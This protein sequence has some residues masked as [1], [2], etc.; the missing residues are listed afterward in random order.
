MELTSVWEADDAGLITRIIPFY[1]RHDAAIVLDATWGKGNFWRY[2][3]QF[4]VVGMDNDKL[5]HAEVL[6]DNQVM[7]F[8]NDTFDAIMYDPP[9]IT[10]SWSD[11]DQSGSYG[12]AG[13]RGSI[14]YLF[15]LF[16]YEAWRILKDDG[17]VV[18]KLADQVHSGM[19]WHQTRE[20]CQCA[21]AEGFQ[22]CDTIVKVR[23]AARPQPSGR[24]QLHASRRHSYFI[25]LRKGKC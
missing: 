9:H 2:D 4:R 24:R 22:H 21:E 6:A 11:W 23:T 10:H 16:L 25:I 20:F 1:L 19:T 8:R 15:P 17:I 7:P 14:G 3:E 18:A 12:V 13:G 5:R